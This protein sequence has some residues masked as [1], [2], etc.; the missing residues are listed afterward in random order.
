MQTVKST[1]EL[2][3]YALD[4]QAELLALERLSRK[5]DENN[6]PLY[7]SYPTSS[8]WKSST[9]PEMFA[10]KFCGDTPPF[11]YFHFPYCKKGCYYCMCYKSVSNN[12]AANDD[13]VQTL[14]REISTKVKMLGPEYFNNIRQMHWGGGT[15]T[16]L[17]CRQI[18][19]VFNT[20]QKHIGFA[21]GDGTTLSLEGYPDETVITQE[22]LRL[23]RDIGFNEISFG[24]Q[25]FDPRVQSA[26]NRNHDSKAVRA[27]IE[28]AKS[29]GFSVNVDLCYGLPFQGINELKKTVGEITSMAP[30]RVAMFT[31]VHHPLIFPMQRAIPASSIPNSF[32]R[33]LM[34]NDA[35]RDFSDSG[36]YKVGYDHFVRSS[37][38]LY[39]ADRS[40][41]IVRDFMGYS[42]EDRKQFVG[43]GSSAIS[44][45]GDS[46]FHNKTSI[47]DYSQDVASGKLPVIEKMGHTLSRD[48][49]LRNE[50]I[51]QHVMC[52]FNIDKKALS[53]KYGISFDIY[54]QPE[55]D[56]LAAYHRDG[57]VDFPDSH[58][59]RINETGEKFIR[60]I[61]YVFDRYYH[62]KRKAA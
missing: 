8:W 35:E 57:L 4:S 47:A 18:D 15:P 5:Y 46:F 45:F 32:L 28:T 19:T 39:K 30:D 21:A 58:T 53:R 25:D 9:G 29:M 24:V 27:L 56:I 31:Y 13:Y 49:V 1:E 12:T 36:Y 23:L 54:F 17:T 60:H 6:I 42:I 55:I 40:G 43:F 11:L 33:V 26:I 38:P 61:A 14:S 7:L 48:D 59:I 16:F 22:K 10:E 51:Q 37:H 3:P 20:M 52:D 50:I 44:F 34:A 41:G 62:S 2:L